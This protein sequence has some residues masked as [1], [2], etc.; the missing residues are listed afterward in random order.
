[1]LKMFNMIVIGERAGSG[2]PNIFRI[3]GSR[4][5]RS[6]S[7]QDLPSRIGSHYRHCYEKRKVA[8]KSND[9]IRELKTGGQETPFWNI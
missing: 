7:L 9:K 1:M 6:L 5:G 3:C 4:A 8:I 2:I